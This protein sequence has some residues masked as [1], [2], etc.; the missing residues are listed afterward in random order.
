[1]HACTQG[2]RAHGHPTLL[3][4]RIAHKDLRWG[5]DCKQAGRRNLQSVRRRKST[6]GPLRARALSQVF[7]LLEVEHS[8]LCKPGTQHV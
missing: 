3:T 6:T 8:P 4:V 5:R 7:D 2:R 1:M